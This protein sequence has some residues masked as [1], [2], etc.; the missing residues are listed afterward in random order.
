MPIPTLP[1][2]PSEGCVQFFS[3][4][5]LWQCKSIFCTP[6]S[7]CVFLSSPSPNFSMFSQLLWP[8][9]KWD[10]S[11]HSSNLSRLWVCQESC[12]S[13]EGLLQTLC[14]TW[15]GW[16]VFFKVF[17]SL[18]SSDASTVQGSSTSSL[19]SNNSLL[20]CV[21]MYTCAG[22]GRGELLV[23]SNMN[24]HIKRYLACLKLRQAP[25]RKW[26]CPCRKEWAAAKKKL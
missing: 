24:C 11:C 18:P 13:G 16:K 1:W 23:C 4:Y 10:W 12:R 26:F 2:K 15:A 7:S 8:C 22:Q 6:P 5:L 14:A 3:L 25:K 9:L 17:T 20:S 19:S 21:T